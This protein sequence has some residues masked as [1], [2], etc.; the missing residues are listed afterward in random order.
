MKTILKYNGIQYDDYE[1]TIDGKIIKVKNNKELKIQFTKQSKKGFVMITCPDKKRKAISIDI[2][3]KE[4]FYLV[5]LKQQLDNISLKNEEWKNYKI[6][7]FE[8][9]DIYISNFGRVYNFKT[10]NLLQ[11]HDNNGYYRFKISDSRK[12]NKLT[13][14]HRAVA[15][16]FVE[17]KNPEEY[18]QVNHIDGNKH[19]NHYMNLEW[20]NGSMNIKHAYDTGLKTA[21][22]VIMNRDIA[23]IIRNEYKNSDISIKKLSE[24]YNVSKTCISNIV[25]FKSWK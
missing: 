3:L 14:I 11:L 7:D 18:T 17:N 1:I 23:E 16:L 13:S 20:C 6:K 9:K 2:A 22:E 25:N 19:N 21:N 12:N 24:K 10:E 15:K 5:L 4:N 8:N